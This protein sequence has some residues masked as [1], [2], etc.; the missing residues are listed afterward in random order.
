M[1]AKLQLAL[2]D[3]SLENALDLLDQVQECVDIVEIGT[4]FMMRC[5]VGVMEK[6]RRSYPGFSLL[7]DAKIMD[8]GSYEA[9]M[10]FSAG[11][12]YVT[13][14]G[15]A[16]DA[17]ICDVVRSAGKCGKKVVAD[18]ICVRNLTERARRL[19]ELGVHVIAVHTGV[20]QQAQGRTPLQDLI[21]IS[22]AVTKT[23]VAVAGGITAGSLEKYL[24]WR[25]DIVIVGGG[26]L[27]AADPADTAKKLKDTIKGF[28]L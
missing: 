4:P 6:I 18:M 3:V 7:L 12:D 27:H 23:Q 25:P 20:D 8:A 10:G 5:G 28:R 11:A 1:N 19:E 15:I 2:D 17:T 26:I 24:I 13:V 21:E 9:E 14:L 22:S 16:E